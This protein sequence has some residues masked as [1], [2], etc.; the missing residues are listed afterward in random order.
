MISRQ[1]TSQTVV[2]LSGDGGVVDLVNGLVRA[3]LDAV[4]TRL[5]VGLLPLGTGNALFH[6]LHRQQYMKEKGEVSPLV[7]GLRTLFRGKAAPLPTFKAEFSK[8]ARLVERGEHVLLGRE[9]VKEI[10][11]LV[12][13]IVASYGFHA[14]LVWESDTPEYRVHGDKRFG[15]AAEQL[16]KE[17]HA[18][19]A[20]V[21][22]LHKTGGGREDTKDG[23]MI[24]LDGDRFNYVLTTMVSNL[25]KTFTISPASKPLD[26][27]LRLVHFGDVGGKKTMDIM[28]AAYNDGAHVGM[29]WPSGAS[30]TIAAAEEEVTGRV[31]GHAK[32]QQQEQGQQQQQQQQQEEESEEETQ[33][34]GYDEADLVR[35]TVHESDPRWRKF[36]IDGT[37]VEVPQGGSMTVR[38]T[39]VDTLL[40]VL[41]DPTVLDT[42]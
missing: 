25:E 18:Y 40:K 9:G 24:K 11:S 35:V 7:L 10:D 1:S 3:D 32:E 15:M 36:C 21:E 39:R 2:L 26:G 41:V 37:I 12:G 5:T 31:N 19:N 38:R 28:M 14:S 33:G 30:T 20:T 6:S 17:S 42:K 29:R 23:V 13:A 27:Q 34:V 8:G 16:L 22:I 4:D